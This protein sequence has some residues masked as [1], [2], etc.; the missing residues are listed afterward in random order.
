MTDTAKNDA[1][2]TA[3]TRLET[4]LSRLAHG[5]ASAREG[6]LTAKTI[7]DEKAEMST[8]LSRLEAENLNLHEQIATLALSSSASDMASTDDDE[9]LAELQAE[10]ATLEQ[11]YQLLKR[12]YA[13]L[14][15]E[16]ELMQQKADA[17][18]AAP[19][20]V[21]DSVDHQLLAENT[22]L[23]HEVAALQAERDGIKAE[24]DKA[25][26]ELETMLEGA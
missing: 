12:Q 19:Q 10:K 1:L 26:A 14:Q 8:K 5:V 20:P 18:E 13:T 2:E 24:L 7:A 21:E 23:R 22:R 17:T 11:N 3:R 25:I 15:D 4:A 16:M 9:R 6:L